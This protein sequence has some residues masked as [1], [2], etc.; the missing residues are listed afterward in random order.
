MKANQFLQKDTNAQTQIRAVVTIL[1]LLIA[2][3]IGVVVY[4]G[5]TDSVDEFSTVTE[6]FYGYTTPTGTNDAVAGS[7]ATAQV[8]TL[9]NSPYSTSN[10]SITVY[11]WNATGN[12]QSAPAVTIN[13]KQVSIPAAPVRAY[14]TPLAYT[15]INVT[16]TSN[17]ASAE[18]SEVTPMANTIF[19]LLPIVALVIV[20]AIIL[21]VVLGFGGSGRKGGG[22]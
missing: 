22:L 20:A 16:Y 6:R 5:V 12:V 4:F 19:K 17:I 21:A 2:I 3:I 15:Q 11:C 7:N 18:G 9:K 1:A 13:H 8:V 14:G 10:S